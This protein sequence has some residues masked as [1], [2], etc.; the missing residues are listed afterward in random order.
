MLEDLKIPFEA[1]SSE[2]DEII[3]LTLPPEVIVKELAKRKAESTYK[4]AKDDDALIIGC[5]TV[6][7]GN[8]KILGKPKNDDDAFQML[9][10]LSEKEHYV[11]SGVCVIRNGQAVCDFEKTTV[12]FRPISDREIK[13][14]I[15]TGEHRDKAGSY[16]IQENGGYFV[17]YVCGD[18]NNVVG[19]P[20]YKLRNL[21][22][23][24]FDTDLFD[25]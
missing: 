8:G 5:D 16:G 19:M 6:V 15:T 25:L 18:I 24:N 1:K 7:Y 23:N 2:T 20:V 12:K 4:A 3:D 13:K 14:Y 17:E 22:L 9:R 21:V 10:S 11:Y